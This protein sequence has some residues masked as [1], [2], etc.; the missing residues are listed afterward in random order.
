MSYIA[1]CIQTTSGDDIDANIAHIAPLFE[2]AIKKGA[3]LIALPENAFYMR[4]EG[5]A[6]GGIFPMDKHPGVQWAQAMATARN[7]W[8]L[9]GSIRS[10]AEDGSEKPMNRSVLVGP[11]GMVAAY[12]D[13]VHL[14]DVTLPDGTHYK[15]SSQAGYGAVPVLARTPLG[16]IGLSICYDLRFPHSYRELALA[17]A[18]ILVVPSAFT[19]P[20]GEAHWHALLRAR[21]IE[22]GAYVLAP[23]QSGEHPGGR[24]TY[25][26]S[27]IIDPWGSVLAEA[28]EAPEVITATIDLKKV[29]EVRAQLP[30]LQHHRALKE[31]KIF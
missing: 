18:Q 3:E 12:Y 30:V 17:G 20:T 22:N 9:V 26:H 13:K 11:A 28:G 23:A 25:G 10:A 14:F 15:E 7:V 1:A 27:V 21:A 8:I 16:S 29:D 5:T 6:G 2:Q 24:T 4:R 31:V 19:R